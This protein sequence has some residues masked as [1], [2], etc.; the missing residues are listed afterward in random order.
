MSLSEHP[1]K[2]YEPEVQSLMDRTPAGMAH[3]ACTG[4]DVLFAENAINSVHLIRRKKS[5]PTLRSHIKGRAARRHPQCLV[6]L[7]FRHFQDEHK[8][9]VFLSRANC[10]SPHD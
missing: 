5:G 6:V 4:P 3:W 9:V 2:P 10:L 8:L 1:S 7:S